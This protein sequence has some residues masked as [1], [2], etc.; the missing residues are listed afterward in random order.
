MTTLP[1]L[2]VSVSVPT[3]K[4][5]LPSC[6]IKTSSYLKAFK[7]LKADFCNTTRGTAYPG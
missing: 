1:L 2:T 4:V 6:T 7:E 3:T 5:T